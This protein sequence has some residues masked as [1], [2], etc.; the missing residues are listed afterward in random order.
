MRCLGSTKHRRAIVDLFL[1]GLSADSRQALR[2]EDFELDHHAGELRKQGIRIRLQHKPFELLALLLE[3]PG[4]L[5]SREDIETKLWPGEEFGDLD[6]R[7]NILINKIRIAL[8]DSAESPRFVETVPT[9]GYRFI[10][11][12]EASVDTEEGREKW[13]SSRPSAIGLTVLLLILAAGYFV[14]QRFRPFNQGSQEKVMMAVL[15]FENFTGNPEQDFFSDGLTEEITARL[16]QLSPADLGVIART[17]AMQY[18]KTE[19]SV[20]EIGQELDVDYLL[21]GSFRREGERVRIAA[22]LIHV[23]SQLHVWTDIYE[24]ELGSILTLQ[25]Q[26]AERTAE[27]LA[28]EMLPSASTK[29][30]EPYAP[31]PPAYEACLKGHYFRDRYTEEGF[32]KSIHYF[33]EAIRLDPDYAPAYAGLASCNCLL[34]GHGLE[35]LLPSEAMPKAKEAALKALELDDTLAEAHA[36]LAMV[37]LKYDWDF[38]AAEEAFQKAIELNPS[39]AQARLWYSTFLEAMGRF[40]EAVMQAKAGRDL[41][42]LS[43]GANVNLGMQLLKAG[44]SQEAIA[45]IEA[46]LELNPN[47]WG[48]RCALGNYY[49]R[50]GRY[51]KAQ[52]EFRRGVT[53]SGGNTVSLAS[54]GYAY[55]VSGKKGDALR[56]LEQL[57]GM[58]EQRYVSPAFFACIYAGVAEA[59]KAFES[60]EGAF[61]LRSRYLV[62]LKVAPEFERLRADPR[63]ED[64]SARI[65]LPPHSGT[66]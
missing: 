23:G 47:F 21:E 9:R 34:A 64:L 32:R 28:V 10:G 50:Q 58:S 5:V 46:A 1:M 36:V 44:R 22:Q 45:Q 12:V 35:V 60:L 31:S 42:P 11:S 17:S 19:K 55:G 14:A 24:G 16:G 39:Y 57:K 51:E 8:H 6:H 59:D 66:D 53:L 52:E 25:G 13:L 33:Q 20:Q 56:I 62:W 15:P 27:S 49:S 38:S 63:F 40:S 30:T 3:R 61:E 26:V 65:G 29:N 37:F 7:L 2:F 43:L 41:D 18:K 54:L 4:E 48:A